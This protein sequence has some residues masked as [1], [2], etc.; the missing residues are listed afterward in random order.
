MEVKIVGTFLLA[1]FLLPHQT[2]LNFGEKMGG[3]DLFGVATLLGGMGPKPIKKLSFGAVLCSSYMKGFLP[4][5][6]GGYCRVWAI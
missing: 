4:C 2:I 1:T 3:R 6:G 5:G